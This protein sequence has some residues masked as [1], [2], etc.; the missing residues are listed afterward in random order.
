MLR[1]ERESVR[2]LI[3]RGFSDAVEH[4]CQASECILP[5]MLDRGAR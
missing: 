5:G 3:E 2:E 1:L 4:D